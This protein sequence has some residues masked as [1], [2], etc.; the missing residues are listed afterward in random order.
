LG[1][2]AVCFQEVDDFEYREA[3]YSLHHSMQRMLE[4]ASKARD[5]GAHLCVTVRQCNVWAD[6]S[7]T[8]MQASPA[9]QA[10]ELACGA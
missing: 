9:G 2:I 5:N 8:D 10:A 3:R 6:R 1:F 7:S 4:I